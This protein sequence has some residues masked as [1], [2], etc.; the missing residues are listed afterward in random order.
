MAKQTGPTQVVPHSFREA[1]PAPTR[2]KESVPSNQ[3]TLGDAN[4]NAVTVASLGAQLLRLYDN[5]MIGVPE[6]RINYF[7]Q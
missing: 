6:D 1:W 2:G 3:G 7:S 4:P 5:V